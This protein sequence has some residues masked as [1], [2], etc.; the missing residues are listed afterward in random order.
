MSGKPETMARPAPPNKAS[1][2]QRLAKATLMYVPNP[3]PQFVARNDPVGNALCGVPRCDGRHFGP[4]GTAQRPF[5]TALRHFELGDLVSN[6]VHSVQ[7][8]RQAEHLLGGA[9]GG[10]DLHFLE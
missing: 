3:M 7:E 9:V 1:R 4:P 8:A 6:I 5:P 2:F 10:L